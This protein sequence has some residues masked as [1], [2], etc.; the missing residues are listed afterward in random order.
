MV[1]KIIQSSPSQHLH[2]DIE[3]KGLIRLAM[4]AS[5]TIAFDPME[6]ALHKAYEKSLQND[7]RKQFKMIHEYPL[8]G[9][10]PM[11]THI[12][13]DES[14]NLIIAAKGAPEALINISTLSDIEKKQIHDAIKTITN[15]GY[16]ILG[17]GESVFK[18]NKY[19]ETQQELQ[20]QFKGIVAFYDPPKK[21]ITEV[22]NNFYSAGIIV[23]IITGDNAAT[24]TAIAKQVGLSL[25]RAKSSFTSSAKSSARA[26][27][28]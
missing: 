2:E 24:T 26:E 25:V 16:R 15:D 12:F 17:V 23:K 22:F 9:K 18:G 13:K 19:P 20:F 14:D 6:I 10:P 4:L 3:E 21:N 8:D 7:E 1:K 11:M 28:P 5:E 27:T